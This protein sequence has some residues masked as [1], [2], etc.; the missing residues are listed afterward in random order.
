MANALKEACTHI[1]PDTHECSV[2]DRSDC[3]NCVSFLYPECTC[4]AKTPIMRL[5]M[6]C[7]TSDL[8]FLLGS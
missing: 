4:E 3:P 2:P 1:H 7:V 6:V 8:G 5:L